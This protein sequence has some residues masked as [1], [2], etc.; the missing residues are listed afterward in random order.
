MYRF[1]STVSEHSIIVNIA[2]GMLEFSTMDM[3]T[4][5]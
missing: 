1:Q 5:E 4:S 2:A 3:S